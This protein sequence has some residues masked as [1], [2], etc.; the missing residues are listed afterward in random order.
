[1]TLISREAGTNLFVQ[2]GTNLI[3]QS[4]ITMHKITNRV[5]TRVNLQQN[6]AYT[7]NRKY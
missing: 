3:V 4:R 6:D 2:T 1:M 7:R 5:D